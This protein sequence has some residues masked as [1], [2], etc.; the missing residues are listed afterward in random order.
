MTPDQ[1]KCIQL[2]DCFYAGYSMP[3]YCIDRGIKNPLIVSYDSNFLWELFIQFRY[4]KRIFPKFKLLT[5]EPANV[6][7]SVACVLGAVR[8]DRIDPNDI[9]TCDKIL[10]LTTNRNP[11]FPK[12]KTVYFDELLSQFIRYVYVERPLYHYVC[13]HKDIKVI[14]TPGLVLRDSEYATENEKKYLKKNVFVLRNELR[15]RGQNILQTR[16]DEFGYTNDEVYAILA[17]SGAKTNQDGTTDLLDNPHPL[18]R[19][20]K[21][22]RMTAHQE[23]DYQHTIWCMGTCIFYG[24]GSPYDKTIESYLQQILNENGHEWRVENESQF[25]AGRYQD[26]FYN[27][28]RLPVKEGDIVLI[29]LQNLRADKLPYF[30]CLH[31]FDRP[32]DYGEVFADAGHINERGNQIYA[33][34]FYEYLVENDF[35]RQYEYS[36]I[37]EEF[38]SVHQYGIVKI[39]GGYRFKI[40]L[41]WK[42]IKRSCENSVRLWE[43]S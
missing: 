29:C 25:Y 1:L 39:A 32:H 24:I 27:L 13:R 9:S 8:F 38:P 31:M 30:D 16:F 5:G 37:P 42:S 14:V 15:G 23:G 12:E 22:K 35:F 43:A 3:Q 4:D 28:E 6:A 7:Y 26:I 36:G 10:V 18:V 21:G 2:R 40:S 20:E 34:K 11:M 17:L 41:S 33:R 19:T